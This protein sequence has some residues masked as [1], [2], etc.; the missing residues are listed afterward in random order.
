VVSGDQEFPDAPRLYL[1]G[2]VNPL[3]GQLREIRLEANR[4]ARKI[5]KQL[6][7]LGIPERA[8][9]RASMRTVEE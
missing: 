5:G 7:A 9:P 8:S 4:I 1:I 3:S 2:H 6:A